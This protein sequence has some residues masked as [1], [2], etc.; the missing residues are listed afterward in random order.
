[1]ELKL[2]VC[3]M[4][5]EANIQAVAALQP[6]YMGFI[7]YGKS[8]RYIGENYSIPG[9]FPDTIK[10]VGV[11]VNESEENMTEAV[12]ILKLDYLQLHGH[13]SVDVCRSLKQKGIGVIKAFSIGEDFDFAVT[14]P[15]KEV[16]DFF[17]FDTKGKYYGGNAQVF[18]WSILHKYNQQ[19]PFF[20]SGGIAAENVSAVKALAGMNIHALDVNSG[21]EDAPAVKSITKLQ[22]L[23]AASN[24]EGIKL[25]S[26]N[27][28]TIV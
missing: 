2:K 28:K 12:R 27:K 10:K 1:M 14:Q 11:F 4:R 6:H 13:E 19:V 8:P 7:L 22:A 17:L 20:L 23:I 5:D 21:V 16:V 15:Y 9:S 25:T 26:D 18:D 3:G 24:A